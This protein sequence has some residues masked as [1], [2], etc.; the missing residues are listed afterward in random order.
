MNSKMLNNVL[1]QDYN[2]RGLASQGGLTNSLTA[3]LYHSSSIPL[4]LRALDQSSAQRGQVLVAG[5]WHSTKGS[6]MLR[7]Q[8]PALPFT[9]QQHQCTQSQQKDIE[10]GARLQGDK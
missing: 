10:D 7:S 9:H 2:H 4:S 5:R 6:E 3:L 1:H 8:K